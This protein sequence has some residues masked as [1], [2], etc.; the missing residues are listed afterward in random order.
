MYCNK[1]GLLNKLQ[2]AQTCTRMLTEN[3]LVLDPFYTQ[4]IQTV[5][6]GGL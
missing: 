1:R 3:K 2:E 5:D 4:N 6:V